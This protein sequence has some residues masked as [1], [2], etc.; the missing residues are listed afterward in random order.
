MQKELLAEMAIVVFGLYNSLHGG[1]Y[2][3]LGLDFE[4][5]GPSVHERNYL[6]TSYA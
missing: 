6:A 1:P 2:D 3:P 5:E 4:N